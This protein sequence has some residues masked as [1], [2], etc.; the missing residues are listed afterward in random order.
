MTPA[1]ELLAAAR[2]RWPLCG[3]SARCARA[4]NRVVARRHAASG[5]GAAI[6]PVVWVPNLTALVAGSANTGNCHRLSVRP[7]RACRAQH[8]QEASCRSGRVAVKCSGQ[9]RAQAAGWARSSAL[10][11]C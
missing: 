9:L 4:R 10:S 6:L 2:I 3:R 7:A 11:R 1:A 5:R 8:A